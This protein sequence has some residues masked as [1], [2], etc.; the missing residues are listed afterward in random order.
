MTA[1][2]VFEIMAVLAFGGMV[3]IEI[4]RSEAGLNLRSNRVKGRK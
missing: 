1:L 3:Y 4:K 2:I